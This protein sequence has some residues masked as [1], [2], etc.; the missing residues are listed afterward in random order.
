MFTKRKCLQ[1]KKNMG[2][3]RPEGVVYV[4]LL[5]KIV[6]KKL[7]LKE[8]STPARYSRVHLLKTLPGEKTL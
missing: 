6:E 1:L 4:K 8:P 7:L 3:K 5:K 2:G